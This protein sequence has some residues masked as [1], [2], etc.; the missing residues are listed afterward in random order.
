MREH[1]FTASPVN[2]EDPVVLRNLSEPDVGQDPVRRLQDR[3]QCAH[4]SGY[5][6]DPHRGPHSPARHAPVP[7]RA[8][9]VPRAEEIAS[10]PRSS[11][12]RMPAA[13]SCPS[14]PSSTTRRMSRPSP[15]TT[16]PSASRSTTSR[17][18][19][20]SPTTSPDFIVKTTDGTVWIVETKGREELDLPQK[21]ARLRQWCDDA[22][23]ASRAEGGPAVPLCL[24]GSGRFR[25]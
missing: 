3:H 22:T 13:S 1:L 8:P 20:T 2:L 7:H 25:A 4:H 24:C 19:A 23:A 14:P 12:S 10:S 18:T 9:A 5:R 16:S 11:A 17:P 21:M 6:H 15:R